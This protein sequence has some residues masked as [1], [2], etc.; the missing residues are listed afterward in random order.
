MS[1]LGCLFVCA[2]V[3]VPIGLAGL[4]WILTKTVTTE[5]DCTIKSAIYQ[6][7]G[8]G[9]K[10]SGY[11]PRIFLTCQDQHRYEISKL[12]QSQ[13]NFLEF[14]QF[15]EEN[16]G[17]EVKLEMGAIRDPLSHVYYVNNIDLTPLGER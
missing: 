17:N 3:F 5:K 1:N 14:H 6:E 16:T 8:G 15:L 13:Q 2:L 4:Y 9:G 7:S 11:S 12:P 10:F